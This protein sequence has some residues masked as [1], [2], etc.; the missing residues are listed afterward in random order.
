MQSTIRE[1]ESVQMRFVRLCYYKHRCVASF[2]AHFKIAKIANFVQKRQ[3]ETN[4]MRGNLF[5]IHKYTQGGCLQLIC[6]SKPLIICKK[7]PLR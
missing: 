6:F 7:D 2:L 1:I 3:L 5:Y 4:V